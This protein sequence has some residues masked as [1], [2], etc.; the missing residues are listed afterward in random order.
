MYVRCVRMHDFAVFSLFGFTKKD[1]PTLPCC[2]R[3]LE[4]WRGQ[5]SVGGA[6]RGNEEQL[7]GS[8]GELQG[9]PVLLA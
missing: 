8:L 5:W 3:V 2:M 1:R 6:R 7:G 4:N 9:I